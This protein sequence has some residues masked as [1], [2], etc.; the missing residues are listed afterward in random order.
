MQDQDL[1]KDQSLENNQNQETDNASPEVE[2]VQNFN[3]SEE[4]PEQETLVFSRPVE[5]PIETRNVSSGENISSNVS[6]DEE[7]LFGKYEIKPWNW[8]PRI[9]KIFAF[10][11]IF[12]ILFLVA[13][14][15]TDI[16]RTKACD[17]PLVGGFCQVLDTLYVGGKVMSSD[18]SFDDRP[19]DGTK[20]DDADV[21][22][23]NK[24]G[25]EPP[26]NYPAGYFQI[27]N[28]EKY[29]LPE[30]IGTIPGMTD[31]PSAVNPSVVTPN[32]TTVNPTTIN[33]TTPNKGIF[34][35]KQQVPKI[36]GGEIQG[37]LPDGIN[38]PATDADSESKN[39]TV[40]K[41][42][43]PDTKKNETNVSKQPGIDS[44][45]IAQFRPNKAPLK[46]LAKDVLE[47]RKNEQGSFDL[48]K[49]FSISMNAVLTD[50]GKF[51]WEK[52][53]YDTKK[54][55][56]DEKMQLIAKSAMEKIGDSQVFK[57]LKDLGADKVNFVLEQND[58]EIRAVVSVSLPTKERAVTMSTFF[59]IL[60][61]QAD[62]NIKEDDKDLRTLMTGLKGTPQDK[63]FAVTFNLDKNTAQA[64]IKEQLDKAE[65]AAEEEKN[66]K[67]NSTAQ[68]F[69]NNTS[70]KK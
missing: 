15:Q 35:R 36:T 68:T 48:S 60:M 6:T 55:T 64:M 17:S 54:F 37:K 10:S 51:D 14:A 63:T 16:L 4:E 52:S 47:M 2:T 20:I 50:D 29:M 30:Q 21:V 18:G 5:V 70:A 65:K 39:P 41:N 66:K 46:D 11:A 57:Y 19:Y 31:F 1:T 23:I 3:L 24:D 45:A 43:K 9:Y 53:K 26:L 8:T 44:E 13:V 42:D 59:K 22:W 27:A 7:E 56:G 49:N 38:I 58:T 69:N 33:P 32:T 67:P 40:S 34:N 62:K 12:N 28:P 25:I 61:G